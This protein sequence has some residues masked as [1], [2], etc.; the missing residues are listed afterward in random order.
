[1]AA[2]VCLPDNNALGFPFLCTLSNICL[3]ICLCWP[4]WSLLRRKDWFYF[5]WPVTFKENLH[6]RNLNFIWISLNVSIPS[7]KKLHLYI[8]IL[9]TL[10]CDPLWLHFNWFS[11]ST[12][13]HQAL[14]LILMLAC[15]AASGVFFKAPQKLW[16]LSPDLQI[17]IF[18]I[19]FSLFSVL[20]RAEAGSKFIPKHFIV[21]NY[22]HSLVTIVTKCHNHLTLTGFLF[23]CIVFHVKNP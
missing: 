7:L 13:N 19:F 23:I 18:Q 6:I 11:I 17:Q 8:N 3:L 16:E 21:T 1:M 10:A 2:P 14:G 22:Y 15:P 5:Q 20:L 4:L 9:L 12:I